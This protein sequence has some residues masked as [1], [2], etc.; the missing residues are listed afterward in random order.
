MKPLFGSKLGGRLIIPYLGASFLTLIL[1]LGLTY[2]NYD[3]QVKSIRKVEMEISVRGS[4][5]INNYIDRIADH[6]K[7]ADAFINCVACPEN[8]NISVLKNLINENPSVSSVFIADIDGINRHGIE[9]YEEAGDLPPS[10]I[11]GENIF[12]KGLEGEIYFSPVHISRYGLPEIDI[13]MPVF[14]KSNAKIGV[15]RAE[16]DLSPMWDVVSRIK[17]GRT[18]YAYVVDAD[19]RLIAYKDISLVKRGFNL[20]G[21]GGVDQFLS[22]ASSPWV[23]RSFINRLVIGSWQPINVTGWGIGVELPVRELLIDLLPLIA[24]AGLSLILFVS[25][26]SIFLVLIFKRLL[27]PV[28]HLKKGVVAVR[29]GDLS[30]RIPVLSDDELGELADSFNTMSGDLLSSRIALESAF[31]KL[32]EEQARLIAS[33][34]SLSIG[35][36]VVDTEG[37]ILISNDAAAGTF[38]LPTS[39]LSLGEVTGLL[40]GV[41]AVRDRLTESI[42]EGKV[43]D[44][45]DIPFQ[46]KFLRIIMG[47]VIVKE[48]ETAVSVI[49]AVIS[50]EDMTE[51]KRIE[52][53]KT[54]FLAIASHEMRTPLSIIRGSMELLQGLPEI[55]ADPEKIGALVDGARKNT[56][57]LFKIVN[58]FIDVVNLEGKMV[59]FDIGPVD[60]PS[61]IREVVHDIG[62]E[63]SNKKIGLGFDES[64]LTEAVSLADRERLRQVLFNVVSN[65]VHY[66]EQGSV[67]VRIEKNGNRFKILVKD[68][69]VGI[70]EDK[71]D[72]LFR[73][74]STVMKTFLRTR[75]YGSGLGL[76]ISRML[77]E[78]MGGEIKLERS[79]PGEGSTFSISVAAAE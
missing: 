51:R 18:G 34:N 28:S 10:D 12:K 2:Y 15:L 21:E 6:L 7:F 70:P 76:Y 22:G 29:S 61:L 26:I 11:S 47:P 59:R 14:D 37:K 17:I 38:G 33:I 50:I 32:R 48:G 25:F 78:S 62:T 74:F 79:V 57:R 35:F 23:Y 43:I 41:F 13:S 71:Q 58:D 19:G 42:R 45:G 8:G 44:S 5:E 1:I 20:R 3:A 24:A 16:I 75:E 66:T 27:T 73:K 65:A 9:R 54:D 55:K 63:A 46:E 30:H 52:Q 69:G 72:M 36:M 31:K 4:A 68:T 39:E 56:I 53:S 64:G 40:E 60:L 67:T 77:V 49:G